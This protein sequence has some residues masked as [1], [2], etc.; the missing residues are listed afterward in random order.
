MA[1]NNIV[2]NNIDNMKQKIFCT[3]VG[4]TNPTCMTVSGN[5]NMIVVSYL[6]NSAPAIET[7]NYT[8]SKK[9]NFIGSSVKFYPEN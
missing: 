5:K 9:L 8:R 7:F 2:L 1:G 6:I 4:Y 3:D